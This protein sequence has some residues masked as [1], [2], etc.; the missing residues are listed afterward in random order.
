MDVRFTR[1]EDTSGV[2]HLISYVESIEPGVSI[3]FPTE[4]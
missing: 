4:S 1:V 3:I 2:K